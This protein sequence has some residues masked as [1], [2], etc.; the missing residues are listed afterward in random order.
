MQASKLTSKKHNRPAIINC[1]LVGHG[2]KKNG[3][4][5]KLCLKTQTVGNM[6]E[7]CLLYSAG[8]QKNFLDHLSAGENGC[9][10]G[11]NCRSVSSTRGGTNGVSAP[12]LPR[13]EAAARSGWA[14]PRC[15]A[16]GGGRAASAHLGGSATASIAL[17][18]AS[19]SAKAQHTCP[20]LRVRAFVPGS[21][22]P[23]SHFKP[24]GRIINWNQ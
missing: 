12:S 9:G 10:L 17:T 3:Q 14:A 6:H 24:G 20:R 4:L 5:I 18:A 2:F 1:R 16:A 13:G 15:P 23:R 7:H 22:A 21:L 8:S 19:T 11:A